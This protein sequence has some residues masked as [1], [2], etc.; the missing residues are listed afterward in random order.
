[1]EPATTGDDA[2]MP[3][4]RSRATRR[5]NGASTVRTVNPYREASTRKLHTSSFSRAEVAVTSEPR[6]V[7]MRKKTSHTFTR[8]SCSNLATSAS[9][10]TLEA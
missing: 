9:S 8:N 2:S 1:V 3:L 5:K 6:P 7:V 10:R 4:A